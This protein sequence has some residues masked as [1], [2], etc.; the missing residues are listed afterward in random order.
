MTNT[1]NYLQHRF[2]CKLYR[3][4]PIEGEK[5]SVILEAG[6]LSPSSFGIEHW[7]FHVAPSEDLLSSC[8][9]QESMKT[10]PVTVVI[11]AKRGKYYEPC[12]EFIRARGIRF[13]GTL[14]EFIDDYKGYYE[15][16]KEEGRLDEWARAQC[17]IAAANMMTAA[18]EL[19]IQSC[20][21]EGYDN[22][23]VLSALGLSGE[24]EL[25][26]LVIAFGYP[27]EEERPKVR[28]SPAEAV[29]F[30]F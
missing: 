21:I 1:L 8:Y 28:L 13:P 26:G 6:R 17:Y 19:G 20:A 25:V 12:G 14:E 22:G 5:L 9:Y 24:E 7:T 16:L 3:R 18:S 2:A 23:K 29:V 4:D 10:A 30:H 15:F 27:A 11:T